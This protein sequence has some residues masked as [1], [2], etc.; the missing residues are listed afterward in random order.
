MC[1]GNYPDAAAA[2]RCEVQFFLTL[3]E[4]TS[5]FAGGGAARPGGCG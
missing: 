5:D 3:N 1:R 4:L 2:F